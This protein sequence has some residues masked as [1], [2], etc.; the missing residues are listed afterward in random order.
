MIHGFCIGGGLGIALQSD[1]RISSDEAIF[2][3]PAVKRGIAYGYDG[4]SDLVD[5]VGPSIAKEIFFTGRNYEASL[6]LKMG[7]IHHMVE[8]EAL[9][10]FVRDC[11][12]IASNAPLSIR[13][14][15]FAINEYLKDPQKEIW[16]K[17][18][19]NGQVF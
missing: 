1:L 13:S 18:K 14:I 10:D 19:R 3:I 2:G 7:L 8:K 5:I 9:E 16:P 17:L 15:K 11:L 6:A 12:E 4:I